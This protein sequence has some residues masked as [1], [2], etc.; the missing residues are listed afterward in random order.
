MHPL[1]TQPRVHWR[2][3]TWSPPPSFQQRAAHPLCVLLF[4]VFP[5]RATRRTSCKLCARLDFSF[6]C[7]V[8]LPGRD[9]Y[10]TS[11]SASVACWLTWGQRRHKENEESIN[12]EQLFS[13]TGAASFV[14]YLLFL[15]CVWK[16]EKPARA[17]V[18]LLKGASL[19]FFACALPRSSACFA[20]QN[21]NWF[22]TWGANLWI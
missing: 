7:S 14:F 1:Q 19:L 11:R 8:F 16:R 15:T 21:L 18:I 2:H 4:L 13:T 22:T 10:C 5:V 17:Q 9:F 3:E 12:M 6:F 20:A